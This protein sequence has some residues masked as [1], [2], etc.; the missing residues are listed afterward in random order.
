MAAPNLKAPEQDGASTAASGTDD[1][2]RPYYARPILTVNGEVCTHN[3]HQLKTLDH[4]NLLQMLTHKV[5]LLTGKVFG[6]NN[7]A[8]RS[9]LIAE[10][11]EIACIP[12]LLPTLCEAGIAEAVVMALRN[13]TPALF[14][15]KCQVLIVALIP[16]LLRSPAARAAFFA[17]KCLSLIT[18]LVRKNVDAVNPNMDAVMALGGTCD[19]VFNV[20]TVKADIAFFKDQ[21]L[22]SE[23]LWSLT[24][25]LMRCEGWE[26]RAY[27]VQ[28]LYCLVKYCDIH[29]RPTFQKEFMDSGAFL[30]FDPIITCQDPG[31]EFYTNQVILLA[32]SLLVMSETKGKALIHYQLINSAAMGKVLRSLNE[33]AVN[34]E[35]CRLVFQLLAMMMLD[36]ED[37]AEIEAGLLKAGGL[38]VLGQYFACPDY[39]MVP[40]QLLLAS[41]AFFQWAC[42]KT[43]T[44]DIHDDLRRLLPAQSAVRMLNWA[45]RFNW[46]DVPSEASVPHVAHNNGRSKEPIRGSNFYRPYVVHNL[47]GCIGVLAHEQNYSFECFQLGLAREIAETFLMAVDVTAQE[48]KMYPSLASLFGAIIRDS[49]PR[50]ATLPNEQRFILGS[51]AVDRLLQTMKAQ[52]NIDTRL[53]VHPNLPATYRRVLREMEPWLLSREQGNGVGTAKVPPGKDVPT[54]NSQE[55]VGGK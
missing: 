52:Q 16:P 14:S 38:P 34:S 48:A 55:L 33:D 25:G 40:I 31:A 19:M 41:Q 53:A 13:K 27:A 23:A 35:A 24:Q 30:S 1:N 2:E 51:P 10:L 45:R 32:D 6:I 11:H 39:N 9:I 49:V 50:G 36:P 18:A 47:V 22:D 37:G 4:E 44:Y 46:T 17:A 12:D 43:L 28:I 3:S 15:F 26:Y 54:S 20:M 7:E 29:K 42:S 5:N 8:E 21:P